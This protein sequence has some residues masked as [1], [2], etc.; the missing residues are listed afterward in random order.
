MK[1]IV[2]NYLTQ[3]IDEDE[4][5]HEL[6]GEKQYRFFL[7]IIDKKTSDRLIEIESKIKI[8]KNRVENNSGWTVTKTLAYKPC[9]V[10]DSENYDNILNSI[11]RKPEVGFYVP[12][13][14]EGATESEMDIM[15]ENE[16]FY[17]D[18]YNELN[19]LHNLYSAKEL[20]LTNEL[21][22]VNKAIS[23]EEVD[24]LLSSMGYINN[25]YSKKKTI[26]L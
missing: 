21:N 4:K 15:I 8:L 7:S 19:M 13:L 1:D 22:I 9:D 12:G 3:I 14:K 25:S 6:I 5:I 24:F 17:L 26:N 23:D 11:P 2:D 20:I 18:N 10:Y 16:D